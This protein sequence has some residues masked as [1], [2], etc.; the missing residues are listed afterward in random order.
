MVTGKTESGFEFELKKEALDDYEL[1]EVLHKID[2]GEF[3]LVPE[4]VERLLGEEQKEK[5]K[6][7]VRDENGKVS[8]S[9][10]LDEVMQ[11]FRAN[12]ETK[13]L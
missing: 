1:V 10:L 13:N 9:R 4:M 6:E 11:I 2:K 5:L 7:H 12:K 8:A 3:G